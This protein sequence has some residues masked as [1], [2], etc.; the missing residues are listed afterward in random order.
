MSA[1]DVLT[2]VSRQVGRE[3]WLMPLALLTPDCEAAV[4]K[5]TDGQRLNTWERAALT[6]VCRHPHFHR[7]SP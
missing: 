1:D 7:I 6:A 2:W 3:L 4:R 5:T